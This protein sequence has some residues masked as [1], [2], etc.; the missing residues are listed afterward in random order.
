MRFMTLNIL[1][2]KFGAEASVQV[3]HFK[4]NIYYFFV[5]KIF[6]LVNA[7]LCDCHLY[8][9]ILQSGHARIV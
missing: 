6:L 9:M 1:V 8:D 7:L 3:N 2:E 5:D 4:L